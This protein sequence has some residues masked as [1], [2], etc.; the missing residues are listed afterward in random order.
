M[1]RVYVGISSSIN[2]G[3]TGRKTKGGRR[4][5][6]CHWLCS[7]A[8]VAVVLPGARRWLPDRGPARPALRTRRSAFLPVWPQWSDGVCGAEEQVRA[9]PGNADQ[10]CP[11]SVPAPST[12][13]GCV[14]RAA[15]AACARA[16]PRRPGPRR[17]SRPSPWR[18]GSARQRLSQIADFVKII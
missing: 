16:R 1:G 13:S 10:A 18:F 5:R 4:H 9:A 15:W 6:A 11:A 14:P 2:L 12:G 8:G 7:S 17:A 3:Q